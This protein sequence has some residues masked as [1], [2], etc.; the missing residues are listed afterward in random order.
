MRRARSAT[1][2]RLSLRALRG[3]DGQRAEW[4]KAPP[5]RRI[6]GPVRL[7]LRRV[8]G[9][10]RRTRISF[11]CARSRSRRACRSSRG[12]PVPRPAWERRGNHWALL[13]RLHAWS[14]RCTASP[15]RPARDKGCKCSCR[16]TRPPSNRGVRDAGSSVASVAASLNATRARPRSRPPSGSGS[17]RRPPSHARQSRRQVRERAGATSRRRGV[18]LCCGRCHARRGA[19]DTREI[20]RRFGGKKPVCGRPEAID[21]RAEGG[22]RG[23]GCP[24][25]SDL[26]CRCL[27]VARVRRRPSARVAHAKQAQSRRRGTPCSLSETDSRA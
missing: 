19:I 20:H 27:A 14:S 13:R 2:S 8:A 7:A 22:R 12:R 6:L 16:E 3:R 26:W 4:T 11:G 24:P 25:H 1:R 23:A 18:A 15:S 10:R 9:R 17:P 21:V 5:A